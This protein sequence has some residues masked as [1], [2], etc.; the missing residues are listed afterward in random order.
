MNYDL[1]AAVKAQTRTRRTTIE[2]RPIKST[3]AQAD[4]LAR[5]LVRG[6]A[7]WELAEPGIVAAYTRTLGEMGITTDSPADIER[8]IADAADEVLR[9]L[10]EITPLM[11][12]WSLRQERYVRARWQANV[13][14]AASVDL[15]TVIGPFDMRDPLAVWLQRNVALV[16]NVSDDTRARI[17]D[18]VFRGITA[19][20]PAR[21]VAKEITEA[22]GIGRRRAQRIA[23][24]QAA[25]LTASL[26]DERRRQAGIN[27][28]RWR[29]SGKRHPREEHLRRDGKVYSD[30]KPPADRPGQLPWCGCV[31]AP[32]LELD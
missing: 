31:A 29:H 18:I 6:P 20:T 9:L 15:S 16:R 21:D 32:I 3:Q 28:W 4:E 27:R 8:A 1:A 10:F 13:L 12:D 23:S 24:D 14:S 19:R 30:D 25:K 11:Q 22:T 5:I 2:L 17:S 26:A 7:V